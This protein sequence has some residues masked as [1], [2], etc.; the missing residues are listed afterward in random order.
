MDEKLTDDKKIKLILKNALIFWNKPVNESEFLMHFEVLKNYNPVDVFLAYEHL[1]RDPVVKFYPLPGV[2]IEAINGNRRENSILISRNLVSMMNRF[3][4]VLSKAEFDKNF[5]EH[6]RE[7]WII[8]QS[9]GGWS[10]ME[11]EYNQFGTN[12]QNF[13]AQ[14]R[15]I[16]YAVSGK[17]EIQHLLSEKNNIHILG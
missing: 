16:A 7:G 17:K 9:F 1:K 10:Q 2:V 3:G 15:D 11:H 6:A 14:L 4:S 8:V 13:V 12:I 5:G